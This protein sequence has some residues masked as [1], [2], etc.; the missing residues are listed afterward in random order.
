MNGRCTLCRKSVSEFYELCADCF[1][2]LPTVRVFS[3][4]GPCLTQYRR[5][6]TNKATVTVAFRNGS[7]HSLDKAPK[8]SVHEE[9]CPSCQDHQHSQYR[10]GYMD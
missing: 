3:S 4:V 6:R 7:G 8:G 2:T 9:P 1:E 10:E 5:V